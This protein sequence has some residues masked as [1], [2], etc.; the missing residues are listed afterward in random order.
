M[1]IVSVPVPLALSSPS[2]SPPPPQA[3]IPRQQAMQ[4][5]HSEDR[6]A[7]DMTRS[8][9]GSG[10]P[11]HPIAC[12][13]DAVH[14]D[15]AL[16]LSI[17]GRARERRPITGY[18]M[19]GIALLERALCTRF[20][21]KGKFSDLGAAETKFRRRRWGNRHC[22]GTHDSRRGLRRGWNVFRHLRSLGGRRRRRNIP[23]GWGNP[24]GLLGFGGALWGHGG[25]GSPDG[26]LD[27]PVRCAGRDA[28]T[29]LAD[30]LPFALHIVLASSGSGVRR[31]PSRHGDAEKHA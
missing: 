20:R 17:T 8:F 19:A 16:N 25:H 7:A 27:V 22:R 15:R 31:K 5:W 29:V 3:A 4:S 21:V 12:R 2:S 23:R 1:E 28:L 11:C 14:S 13:R 6:S 24:G 26:L 9:P 30:A 18:P 10:M